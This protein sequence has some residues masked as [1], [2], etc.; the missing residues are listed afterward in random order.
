MRKQPKKPNVTDKQLQQ[1]RSLVAMYGK[2]KLMDELKAGIKRECAGVVAVH[3]DVGLLAF[4]SAAQ[5]A[6]LEIS[7]EAAE[8]QAKKN[9]S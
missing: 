6:L 4:V 7:T 5:E 9:E 1:N 2:E 8:R 3:G